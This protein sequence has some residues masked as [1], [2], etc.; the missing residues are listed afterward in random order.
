M[1]ARDELVGEMLATEALPVSAADGRGIVV[2]PEKDREGTSRAS[3]YRL[4]ERLIIWCDPAVAATVAAFESSSDSPGYDDWTSWGDSIGAEFLGSG[5]NRVLRSP[6]DPP[7]HSGLVRMD[8]DA[9]DDVARIAAL[10]EACTE[11]DIDEAE[12]DPDSLDPFIWCTVTDD[13]DVSAFASALEYDKPKDWW[14][15]GVL[16]HPD[17]RRKHLGAACVQALCATLIDN[18][19]RPLY[20][21]EVGNAGSSAL[22]NS[23]GFEIAV[24]LTALR[25]P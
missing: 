17:H 12:I 14:D 24:E 11:D 5:H 1:S 21:H 13:G 4:G 9:P 16:T 18:G 7:D 8:R 2:V 3:C 25:F 6:L 20:R 23:L 22:A 10:L 19:H 15:I